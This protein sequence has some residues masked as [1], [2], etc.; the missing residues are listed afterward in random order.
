MITEKYATDAHDEMTI[1]NDISYSCGELALNTK[2][3]NDD[4]K[5]NVVGT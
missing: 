4:I 2:Y 1:K 3:P 5:E